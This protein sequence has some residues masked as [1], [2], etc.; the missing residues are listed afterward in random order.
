M[1]SR[2]LLLGGA[3][4]QW[5]RLLLGF[6]LGVPQREMPMSNASCCNLSLQC[7]EGLS[8]AGVFPVTV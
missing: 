3:R 7:L 5:V 6:L 1:V 8:L 2:V 4:R